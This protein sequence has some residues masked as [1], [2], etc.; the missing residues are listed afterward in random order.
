MTMRTDAASQAT[1]S[2]CPRL[3]HPT[4]TVGEYHITAHVMSLAPMNHVL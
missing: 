3:N 2:V 1:C 4:I